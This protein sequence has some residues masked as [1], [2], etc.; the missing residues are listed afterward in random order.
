MIRFSLFRPSRLITLLHSVIGIAVLVSAIPVAS[1]EIPLD[2]DDWQLHAD[3]NSIKI[4]TKAQ[5][6]S[7][8][9][10][11]K[12]VA[13]LD[14]PIENIM[15]VMANPKSCLE[16]V[17]GCI[18]SYG[19]DENS[20]NKRYAYS[21]ND[22]PWPVQDRDY[23]L[24]INTRNDSQTGEIF[25]DMFAVSDKISKKS[26]LVRVN[27]AET[28]YIFRPTQDG[29]TEMVWLQHTEPGGAIPSW[30]VNA[31][32]V[33]VPLKSMKALEAV[34]NTEKYSRSE[35]VYDAEGRIVGVKPR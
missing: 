11:F 27:L 14:S 31:L 13:V 35:I 32:I 28:H 15:A 30:L 4:Y 3:R 16:W 24:E 1:A 12:A 23:V 33:D 2:S 25:M 34:A 6:G 22:L 26:E 9:K 29:K 10:A 5:K 17:Y 7:D 20:F 18:E 8:F 21:V 19:F